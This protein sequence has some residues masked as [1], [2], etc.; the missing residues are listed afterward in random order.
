VRSAYVKRAAE[1]WP[2]VWRRARGAAFRG[3]IRFVFRGGSYHAAALTYYSILAVFPAGALVYGLLGLVGAES[4]I[5]DAVDALE[6]RAVESQFVNALSDTLSSAVNQ[7]SD[8]ATIAV[9]ISTGAA[10]YLASRWVRGVARGL[11][12]VLDHEHA[13]SGLRF[14]RQLRD[15]LALLLMFIGALVLLFVGGGLAKGLFGEALSF[16]WE[17]GVYLLAALL[18]AGAYAYIYWFVPSPPRPPLDALIAGAIPGM[19]IWVLATVGFRVFADLWPGYDTNYGVFAT[20]IVAVIWLWLTNMSVLIGGAFA[21]EWARSDDL[22]SPA[23]HVPLDRDT[24][25]HEKA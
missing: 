12:A 22:P 16:L 24:R 9:A 20:L 25:P 7:R 11:D 17:V 23:R 13:G 1:A 10:I 5:H 14:L 8:D 19:L 21:A 4:V 6:D 18:G 2:D 3:T 15:T